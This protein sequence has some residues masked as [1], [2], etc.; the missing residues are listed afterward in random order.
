M[1]R[2]VIKNGTV[3]FK[4]NVTYVTTTIAYFLITFFF[5]ISVGS[6][7]IKINGHFFLNFLLTFDKISS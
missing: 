7:S 1:D 5:I 2:R 3:L 6:I 4:V